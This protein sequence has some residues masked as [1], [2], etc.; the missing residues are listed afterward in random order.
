MDPIRA[1]SS[2]GKG[3]KMVDQEPEKKPSLRTL[4]GKLEEHALQSFLS[5]EI[6]QGIVGHDCALVDN[7]HP[8]ADHG[9]L[10][11]DVCAQ[12]DRMVPGQGLDEFPDRDDLF[13]VEADGGFV[14][15]EH[16]RI[17]DHG[18]RK[19]HTLLVPLGEL[20]D[21]GFPDRF[22]TATG[23]DPVQGIGALRTGYTLDLC[24]ELQIPF[25]GH[26]F[27]HWGM[28]GK[29]AYSL[30]YLHRL[31]KDVETGNGHRSLS[32]GQE[33]GDHPHGGGLAGPV[34]P[35]ESHDLSLLHVEGD[36]FNG[37]KVPVTLG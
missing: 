32:S 26:V 29:I 14:Q 30:L 2:D 24:H 34:G 13:G 37:L 18:L 9:Y 33:P 15:D 4:C 8:V 23:N 25:Y 31:L 27:V 5:R 12:Y 10:W 20:A 28:L 22:E 19:P 1:R 11:Q 36:V 21:N 35:Q 17:V 6:R 7:Q 3:K 16:I